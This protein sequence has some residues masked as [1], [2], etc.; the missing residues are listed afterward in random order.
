MKRADIL[1]E[2]SLPLIQYTVHTPQGQARAVTVL[3]DEVTVANDG[4]L[5]LFREDMLIRAFAP[6]QWLQVHGQPCQ[7]KEARRRME[8]E[9]AYCDE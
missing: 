4:S 3:A 7:M 5:V 8:P 2:S 6:G 9:D 1:H